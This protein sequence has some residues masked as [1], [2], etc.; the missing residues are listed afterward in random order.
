[1]RFETVSR[2]SCGVFPTTIP[3][4]RV[5]HPLDACGISIL[6]AFGASILSPRFKTVDTPMQDRT[7]T[8][9]IGTRNWPKYTVADGGNTIDVSISITT[10]SAAVVETGLK[11][12]QT[13]EVEHIKSTN[14]LMTITHARTNARTRTRSQTICRLKTKTAQTLNQKPAINTIFNLTYFITPPPVGGRG[15]VFGRF[16]SLLQCQQ[17]Y[18]KTAGPICTKFSG[19]VWSDHGTT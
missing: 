11:S 14:Y 18:E 15:I 1:M 12:Q 17:D 10:R 13:S 6:G 2:P 19:K 16:L 9:K 4:G 8:G 5:P 3:G 7:G